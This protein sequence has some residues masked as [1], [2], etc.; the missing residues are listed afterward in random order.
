MTRRRRGTQYQRWKICQGR[1][2]EAAVKVAPYFD[3]AHFASRITCP[4]RVTAGF[5]DEICPPAAV[6]AAYNAL[7][8]KDKEIGHGIN[9]PHTVFSEFHDRYD[10]RWLRQK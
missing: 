3:G 4:V 2:K 7:R 6:Y 10:D 8:V 5:I 9:M 1:D